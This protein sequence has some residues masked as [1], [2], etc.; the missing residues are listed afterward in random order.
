M[1]DHDIAEKMYSGG[2]EP[3]ACDMGAVGE[4]CFIVVELVDDHIDQLRRESWLASQTRGA[5]HDVWG[6]T[7]AERRETK[8]RVAMLQRTRNLVG[9][10]LVSEGSMMVSECSEP[11]RNVCDSQSA[12]ADAG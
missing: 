2:R 11:S 7:S 8:N 12:F 5:L 6:T 3:A 9:A 10:I 4:G 1:V